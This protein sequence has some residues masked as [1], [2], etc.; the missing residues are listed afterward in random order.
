M[1]FLAITFFAMSTFLDAHSLHAADGGSERGVAA[2]V[3]IDVAAPSVKYD[4]M[5]F[6]GFLEH[7]GQQVYGGVFDPGNP[8]SDQDGIRQDVVAALKEL[9]TPVVRWPGGCFVSGYHWEGGVGAVR[10]P[11]DDMAWGVIEPNTFGTDEYIKLCRQAGW[12]PYICTNA[13]NGTIAEMRN[14]VEYCNASAGKYA[15][16]RK[17]TGHAAPQTVPYWSVGN[18]NYHPTEIGHKDSAHWAPFVSEAAREM[19]AVDPT[20]KLTAAA[21]SDPAWT[22]PLLK[23]AGPYLDLISIHSYWLP[24][25]GSNDT[26][27]YLHCIMRSNGPE[28]EIKKV[29]GILDQSGYRGKIKIA[30]DE[31]NMRSW[32]HPGF[33]RTTVQNYA[34]PEVIHLIAAREKNEIASQY[35]MADAL[36]TACFFNACLRH[37]DDVVM[38]N[39]A[40]LVNTR[41]PLYVHPKG[42]VKRTHFHAMAMYASELEARVG[43]VKVEAD[44]LTEGKKS[45]PVVD[46]IATV[47]DAGSRWSIAL[48]N[49]HPSAAVACKVQFKDLPLDGEVDAVVLAGDS[50]EAF[51]DRE[52]PDRVTPVKQKLKSKAGVVA[53]P[54]HSLTIIHLKSAGV[55]PPPGG[56]PD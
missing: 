40:P 9:G 17:A 10:K 31:W 42:I 41:G 49:R 2:T 48:V 55:L 53:L 13:G 47:S 25:W 51:N 6:G 52:H 44:P 12:Q 14:W 1:K 3:T 18:E 19:K 16:L 7:F 23:A 56:R 24:L 21:Q 54:A 28:D 15:D 8:L 26:P 20:I 45:L 36:F 33:P 22:L 39:I 27:S 34:D 30:Y 46:A 38:A 29:I 37:A 32:H 50:T 43:S 11:V 4:R 5:I 35:T